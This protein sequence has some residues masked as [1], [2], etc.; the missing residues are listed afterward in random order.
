MTI[1]DAWNK[2]IS[3]AIIRCAYKGFYIIVITEESVK[4]SFVADELSFACSQG[5]W[6]VPV[7]LEC[8]SKL[9]YFKEIE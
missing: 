3:D 9:N 5:A 4:S 1:G 6:I 8:V 2:Q 7:V